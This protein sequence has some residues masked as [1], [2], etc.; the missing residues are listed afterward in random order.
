[1]L[2]YMIFILWSAWL[3]LNI[4]RVWLLLW[5]YPIGS[6]GYLPQRVWVTLVEG[7]RMMMQASPTPCVCLQ[8]METAIFVRFRLRCIGRP[9]QLVSKRQRQRSHKKNIYDPVCPVNCKLNRSLGR[10]SEWVQGPSFCRK[11][12]W[13]CLNPHFAG[14]YIRPRLLGGNFFSREATV[15]RDGYCERCQ[16]QRGHELCLTMV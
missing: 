8:S 15:K 14:S 16:S 6:A 11:V 3:K 1:M 9:L 4:V 10:T 5:L 7:A 13:L 2:W 12:I